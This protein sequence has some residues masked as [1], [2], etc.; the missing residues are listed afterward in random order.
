[1]DTKRYAVMGAGE[2]GCYL[3]RTLSAGGH[4]VKLI[5]SDPKKQQMVEDQLDVVFVLGNGTHMATLEAA[6]VGQCDVFV[7]ASSSDD[8][9][10]VASLLAKRLGV[11]A[12]RLGEPKTVV[13]VATAEWVTT[14]YGRIY[15]TAFEADLLLSTQLLTTTRVLNS[16][17]GYNTLD[18]EYL[19]DGAIQV[20]RT[21]VEAGSLL[22]TTRLADVD[23]PHGSLV[24]AFITDNELR[25]PSG[26]DRAEPG[27]D[28]IIVGTP[29]VIDEVEHRVSGHAR[30]VGRV[31][32]AGGGSTAH[33]VADGLKRKVKTIKII[34]SN[35]SRAEEL[36]TDYPDYEIVH[37]DATDRSFL[38]S[39]GIG[40]ARAFIALTGHDESNLM[41]CLLAQELGVEQ[42]TALVRKSDTSSL[43]RKVGLI[44][45]VSPR[46]VAAERIRTYV[47]RNY[48]SEI[49]SLE[50][51]DAQFMPRRVHAQTPAAGCTL[52]SLDMP[53]GLVVAAVLH[54]DRAIV[55]RGDQQLEVGDKVILFVR[56]S[57]AQLA[58][59]VFPGPD[60]E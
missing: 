43:W 21:R 9:N 55:P 24:V 19:E 10:L 29:D 56:K 51:D 54:N 4:Q 39:E 58:Q 33:A 12:K 13:R 37:G 6:E 45:V 17:L 14:K 46:T 35:R 34:E 2:V 22:N 53:Q 47:E 25:V 30:P 31:V 60:N 38:E 50:N 32:I 36:A 44:D 49:L 40:N 20:R 18:V 26:G 3:A 11:L 7:A 23:L 52:N 1:M 59:L 28:A 42:M 48:E 27:D 5:D 41:A 16:V 8:A 15:K 57:D